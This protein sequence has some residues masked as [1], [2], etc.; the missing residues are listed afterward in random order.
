MG[1]YQIYYIIDGVRA[2]GCMSGNPA[3][4]TAEETFIAACHAAIEMIQQGRGER[5][6]V[7]G[8]GYSHT[9]VRPAPKPVQLEL[10]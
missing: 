7:V 10:F 3:L 8:C 4:T 5:V 1:A 2:G 6:E 9:Y